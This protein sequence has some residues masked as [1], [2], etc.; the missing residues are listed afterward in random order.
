MTLV[1]MSPNLPNAID[2]T[3]AVEQL[4]DV[5]GLSPAQFRPKEGQQLLPQGQPVQ[6]GIPANINTQNEQQLF[7]NA[8]VQV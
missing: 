8:N 3:A 6:G 4:L 2:S 7:T 1:Q 5:L